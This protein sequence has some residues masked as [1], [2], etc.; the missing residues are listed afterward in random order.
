MTVAKERVYKNP[1]DLRGTDNCPV[2]GQAMKVQKGLMLGMP[3]R[4]LTCGKRDHHVV[5]LRPRGE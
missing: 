4:R 5:I 2:C 3:V 1:G